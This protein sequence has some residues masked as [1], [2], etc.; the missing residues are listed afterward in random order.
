MLG[1]GAVKLLKKKDDGSIMYEMITL[2]L[3]LTMIAFLVT[4]LYERQ[5]KSVKI[6]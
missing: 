4:L 1:G 6:R 5:I 2:I 3:I